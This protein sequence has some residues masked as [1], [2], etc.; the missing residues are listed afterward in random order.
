[1]AGCPGVRYALCVVRVCG[2]A[3]CVCVLYYPQLLFYFIIN[4]MCVAGD[5]II[6][7][8]EIIKSYSN[9][10]QNHVHRVG[11]ELNVYG[12]LLLLCV[13]VCDVCLVFTLCEPHMWDIFI[14]FA[15]SP[16]S[17]FSTLLHPGSSVLR[18]LL[19][20]FFYEA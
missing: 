20:P 8:R 2:S 10:M 17:L 14:H 19:F 13:C 12:V 15:P 11:Y 3:V 9:K 18:L 4:A 7:C 1:M 5:V 16:P 6:L